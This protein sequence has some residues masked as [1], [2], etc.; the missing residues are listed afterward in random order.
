MAA[1]ETTVV[2]T[3]DNERVT[4]RVGCRV[5]V[6]MAMIMGLF[7]CCGMSSVYMLGVDGNDERMVIYLSIVDIR[8]YG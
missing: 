5:T 1:A 8:N 7:F 4:Y 3:G 6:L 2:R